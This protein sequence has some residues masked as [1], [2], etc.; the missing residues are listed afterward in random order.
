MH[1]YRQHV[2]AQLEVI[3]RDVIPAFVNVL[4]ADQTAPKIT[5]LIP[6]PRVLRPAWW[7]MIPVRLKVTSTDNC[8]S[9]PKCRIISVT[10]NDPYDKDDDDDKKGGYKKARWVITGDL[11]LELRAIPSTRKF[12]R[13]YRITIECVD[14]AGN[15]TTRTTS[16]SVARSEK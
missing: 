1:F 16:V 6:S 12:T 15:R 13:I 11:S 14:A 3:D 2:V 9:A 5:M 8:D 7:Q 10:S 4:V